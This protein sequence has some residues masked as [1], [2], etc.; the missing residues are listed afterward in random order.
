MSTKMSTRRQ[1]DVNQ[2]KSFPYSRHQNLITRYPH[3]RNVYP[4]WVGCPIRTSDRL[5][6]SAA[7]QPDRIASSLSLPQRTAMQEVPNQPTRKKYQIL[8]TIPIPIT[9]IIVSN[10]SKPCFEIERRKHHENLRLLQSQHRTSEFS[11]TD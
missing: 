2:T 8:L 4:P 10:L 9:I 1:P 7:V 6:V 3:E 11:A 5:T